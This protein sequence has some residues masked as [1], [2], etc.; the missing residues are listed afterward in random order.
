MLFI[1]ETVTLDYKALIMLLKRKKTECQCEPNECEHVATS[2]GLCGKGLAVE[3]CAFCNVIRVCDYLTSFL[4]LLDI[5][6]FHF[7]GIFNYPAHILSTN[8]CQF[9]T[10]FQIIYDWVFA[11]LNLPVFVLFLFLSNKGCECPD[12]PRGESCSECF[13][14]SKANIGE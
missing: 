1:F 10:V 9:C 4:H 11:Q 3:C 8:N 7:V 12:V 6:F 14:K 13:L 5:F 2:D